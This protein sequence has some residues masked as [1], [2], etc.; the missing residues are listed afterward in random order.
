VATEHLHRQH[1]LLQRLWDKEGLYIALPKK[2]DGEQ[3]GGGRTAVPV[4]DHTSQLTDTEMQADAHT[5]LL[6]SD[7]VETLHSA[8]VQISDDDA[9]DLSDDIGQKESRPA[10]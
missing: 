6:K 5:T 10:A 9:E 1:L 8:F 4:I 3:G 7:P 2:T